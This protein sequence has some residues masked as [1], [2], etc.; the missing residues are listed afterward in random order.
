M[1]NVDEKKIQKDFELSPK[2]FVQKCALAKAE[3][4]FQQ[5]KTKNSIPDLIVACDT[6]VGFNFNF[7]IWSNMLFSIFLFNFEEF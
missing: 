6:I 3:D 5:E 7:F 2:E 4:V 1:S